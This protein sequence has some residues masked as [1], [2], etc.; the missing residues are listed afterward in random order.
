LSLWVLVKIWGLAN[1]IG[2]LVSWGMVFPP[3]P[4]HSNLGQT[5]FM[6]LQQL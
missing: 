2:L 3:P 5:L 1:L 4:P 6:K